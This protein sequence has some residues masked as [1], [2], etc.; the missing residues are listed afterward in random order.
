[1]PIKGREDGF[2]GMIISSVLDI[3]IFLYTKG[4]SREDAGWYLDKIEV[5][6]DLWAGGE[7][8]LNL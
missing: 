3:L 4:H 5:I 7:I 2:K 1:M 8:Q 6:I